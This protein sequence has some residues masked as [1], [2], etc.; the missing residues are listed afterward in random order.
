MLEKLIVEI[1]VVIKLILIKMRIFYFNNT[2]IYFFCCFEIY[3]N[4]EISIY[5]EGES[6][7]IYDD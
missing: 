7:V 3:L 5:C 4:C 2:D 1:K 6:K